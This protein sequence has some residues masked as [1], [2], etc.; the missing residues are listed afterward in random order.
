MIVL[1]TLLI[2][3]FKNKSQVY[4]QVGMRHALCIVIMYRIHLRPHF[5]SGIL[6]ATNQ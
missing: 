4:F 6:E 5:L 1:L 3:I 2:Y